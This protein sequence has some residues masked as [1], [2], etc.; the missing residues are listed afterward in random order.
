[1]LK[2]PGKPLGNWGNAALWGKHLVRVGI[3]A[4]LIAELAGDR[5][6]LLDLLNLNKKLRNNEKFKRFLGKQDKSIKKSKSARAARIMISIAQA[7]A[8]DAGT[9]WLHNKLIAPAAMR[10]DLRPL[11]LEPIVVEADLDGDQS[12]PQGGAPGA[13]F[14]QWQS[15]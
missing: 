14:D 10:R 8:L 1:V 4:N 15:I 9:N 6:A 2:K 3:L 5:N 12:G 11:E 7:I 13:H